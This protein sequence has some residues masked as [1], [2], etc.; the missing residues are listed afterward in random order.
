MALIPFGVLSAAAGVVG[1]ISIAAYFSGGADNSNAKTT[2]DKFAFP[3]DTRST[4]GTG[5]ANTAQS[6]AG[7]ANSGVAGYA[8]PNG[9]TNKFAF[10]SD[11]R[12]TIGAITNAGFLAGFANT[13]VAGYFAGGNGSTVTRIAFLSDI[14]STTTSL[15]GG[16]YYVA[17]FADRAVAGYV[18]GGDTTPGDTRVNTVDKFAFPGET[19]TTLGTGMSSVRALHFAMANYGTAGYAGGGFTNA[20]AVTGVDK[21]AFPSDTRSTLGTGLA[22]AKTFVS[23][24]EDTGVGGYVGNGANEN[25]VNKFAFPSDTRSTLAAGFSVSR[26]GYQAFANQGS[27]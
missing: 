12:S 20:G 27:F 22:V 8:M 24:T 16:R 23:A 18:A 1:R 15:S 21:F 5:L 25:T 17:G 3:S 7:M 19:R 26:W 14:I 4:L 9:T 11:T 6:G 2:V 10:P 13:G